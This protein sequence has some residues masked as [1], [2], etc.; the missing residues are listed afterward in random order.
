MSNS[1]PAYEIRLGSVKATIWPHHSEKGVRFNVTICRLYRDEDA[2]KTSE[3]FG[4]DELPLAIK[5][6]D[7]AHTWILTTGTTVSGPENGGTL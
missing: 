2:W 7:M 5:A 4:R 6:L 1:K 3:S